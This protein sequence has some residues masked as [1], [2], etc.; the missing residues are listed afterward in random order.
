MRQ[1]QISFVQNT[2]WYFSVPAMLLALGTEKDPILLAL[3]MSVAGVIERSPNAKSFAIRT[4][5][6]LRLCSPLSHKSILYLD[7]NEIAR[8]PVVQT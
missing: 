8:N 1:Y 6:S 4:I 2:R 7:I 3:T 5:R